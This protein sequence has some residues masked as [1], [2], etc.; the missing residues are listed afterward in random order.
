M[1]QFL[2]KFQD[3]ERQKLYRGEGVEIKIKEQRDKN[4]RKQAVELGL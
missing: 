4:K 3:F 2:S 1:H